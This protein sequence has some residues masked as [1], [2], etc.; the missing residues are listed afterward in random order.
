MDLAQLRNDWTTLSTDDP[1]W[2]VYS[3]PD[4]RGTWDVG[5]FLATGEEEVSRVLDGLA[6]VRPGATRDSVLDFGS[7][8]GRLT[9][10]LSRAFVRAVGV[11][12]AEPM[13]AQARRLDPEGQC[14]F[15]LNVA[16]DLQVF[17]DAEFDLVY[18]SI[19]LQHIPPDLVL[20]YIAEFFRVLRPGGLAT[21]TMPSH[22]EPTLRGRLYRVLPFGLINA[23]KRRRDG[24]LMAMHHV[25]RSKLV[26]YLL[27]VGFEVIATE[28]DGSAGP[29]WVAYRYIVAKPA[30]ERKV[31]TSTD[32]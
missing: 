13:I 5:E 30:A 25:S 18:S 19:V 29:N 28:Q 4:K 2:A 32:G 20:S 3:S 14:E 9:L 17:N 22:P 7:G 27:D 26:A 16:P 21:F 10:P 24:S 31:S 1:F 12:I 15:V 11:D 23:Y 8:V 6:Q